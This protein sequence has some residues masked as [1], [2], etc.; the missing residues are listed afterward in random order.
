MKKKFYSTSDLSTS[1]FQNIMKN[2]I[3]FSY[4]DSRLCII[5]SQKA[6]ESH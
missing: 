3:D 4:P 5:F 2:L 1:I 6:S